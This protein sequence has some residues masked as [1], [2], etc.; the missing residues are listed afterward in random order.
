[1]PIF[2]KSK[3]KPENVYGVVIDDVTAQLSPKKREEI[4]KLNSYVTN[5]FY[6][7]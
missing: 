7:R 6:E 1:M 5:E 2:G 3:K 4:E